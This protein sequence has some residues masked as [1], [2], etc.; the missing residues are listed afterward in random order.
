MRHEQEVPTFDLV[1]CLSRAMD[2]I[3]SRMANHHLRVAYICNAMAEE[4]GM[5]AS[6]REL[7]L[8]AGTLHDAGAISL[9][10]RLALNEFEASNVEPHCERGYQFLLA[11]EPF[12]AIARQV[13]YH[14]LHWEGGKGE[15]VSGNPVPLESHLLHLADRVDSL[16]DLRKPVLLQRR[17]IC[18]ELRRYSG[19]RFRPD[20]VEAFLGCA[21]KEYF[22]LD[23]VSPT[24]EPLL[25]ASVREGG[26]LLN[27]EGLLGIAGLFCRVIDFRSRFT[28]V[29]SSGVASVAET[30]ARLAGLPDKECMKVR[31]AGKFHDL[32]K[33]AVPPEIL[34]KATRLQ[35]SERAVMTTHTYHTYRILESIKGLE[36]INAWA[37]FHHERPDGKGYPFRISGEEYSFCCRI[38]SVADVFTALTE[39]R[40]YRRGMD[41][42][43]T[44]N[45]LL[46]M[47]EDF[48]LDNEL[49]ATVRGNFDQMNDARRSA[50]SAALRE[51]EGFTRATD[52][53]PP[54][55]MP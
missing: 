33:L 53:G 52:Q 37:S 23:I 16:I 44:L 5:D 9:G 3:D 27:L 24:I 30:L 51:Y 42:R 49:V 13:R 45:T 54:I 35:Q 41:S 32:G 50:Q 31:L 1:R 38:M 10:E 4:L 25:A 39:D 20:L 11:Y 47:A 14:H 40:P 7:V 26:A 8:T 48:Q 22:W 21:C 46:K 6:A 34:E 18:R 43:E 19:S 15:G 17:E 28:A 2:L 12:H 29:H 55:R 36:E